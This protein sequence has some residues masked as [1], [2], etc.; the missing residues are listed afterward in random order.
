[1]TVG[2]THIT[3]QEC[4]S[5]GKPYITRSAGSG[6]IRLLPVLP[7]IFLLVLQNASAFITRSTHEA[8]KRKW[9]SES[10]QNRAALDRSRAEVSAVAN[11]LVKVD[12]NKREAESKA[13]KISVDLTRV[14]NELATK[15]NELKTIQANLNKT[16][17]EKNDTKA[18]SEKT[19]KAAADALAASKQEIIKLE[20]ERNDAI[21]K[22]QQEKSALDNTIATLRGNLAN[23][24]KEKSTL[25]EQI[26]AAEEA[27]KQHSEAAQ[28]ELEMLK[29]NHAQESEQLKKEIAEGANQLNQKVE[30]LVK[31]QQEAADM[32]E[33]SV[34]AEEA[35]KADIETLKAEVIRLK[36]SL[37]TQLQDMKNA[38]TLA[39]QKEAE[40]HAK[41]EAEKKHLNDVIINC[42]ESELRMLSKLD[43]LQT[44]LTTLEAEKRQLENKSKIIIMKLTAKIKEEVS[45]A[46]QT[47]AKYDATI[48]ACGEAEL[49]TLM[50]IDD[51]STSLNE[52]LE[53][54]ESLK[55]LI[56]RLYAEYEAAQ[57]KLK[58]YGDE[59]QKRKV[60]T[61]TR[62]GPKS[63]QLPGDQKVA[64]DEPRF[65]PP[66][67]IHDQRS[68]NPDGQ[69][70]AYRKPQAWPG[71]NPQPNWNAPQRQQGARYGG[72]QQPTGYAPLQQQGARYGEQQQ[73]QLQ[74]QMGYG[75]PQPRRGGQQSRPQLQQQHPA[76]I[77]QQR[78]GGFVG[79]QPQQPTYI[80][81]QPSAY[82]TPQQPV[83]YG[84][85][86]QGQ[87]QPAYIPQQ[88]MMYGRQQPQPQQQLQSTGYAQQPQPTYQQQ[89]MEYGGGQQFQPQQQF[90]QPNWN[91]PMQQR[92]RRGGQQSQSQQPTGSVPPQKPVDD[93][94]G[95][96][97]LSEKQAKLVE[98]AIDTLV[99]ALM[100][101][102]D[103]NVEQV[104]AAMNLVGAGIV[105]SEKNESASD[106][107]NKV[108]SI[109]ESA[110]KQ[111]N[112]EI[113]ALAIEEMARRYAQ[114]KTFL[115]E[116][117]NHLYGPNGAVITSWQ[118]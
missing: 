12:S 117:L 30:E 58:D 60:W 51:L 52:T 112:K 18:S 93:D 39:Q 76:Y 64:S 7:A 16:V 2:T 57:A 10:Q 43:E 20:K 92:P 19:I 102:T 65:V 74:Q 113:L 97:V 15:Q 81:Q 99:T 47:Q 14:N 24:E 66:P 8:E 84:R 98:L 77:P 115:D 36:S 59:M 80:P 109:I 55:D 71:Y 100:K 38:E 17:Q 3:N 42:Q 21:S 103:G 31:I 95:K 110:E 87:Q 54:N 70:V 40:L 78:H 50:L 32:K 73:V 48:K 116:S 90:Q 45:K 107:P 33:K 91:A 68:S 27:Q 96:K 9:E 86:P 25:G 101:M 114:R 23:S 89:Q 35:Y 29:S 94:G 83:G 53:S 26:K 6:L 22:A 105:H 11:Q 82:M 56:Q 85:A 69:V 37:E 41:T 67:A 4:R 63:H 104:D 28:R 111:F 88:Q 1:M 72:Q 34:V 108:A 5:S 79:Q 75:R 118:K 106:L 49:R 46:R 13:A 61:V 62:L 44:D